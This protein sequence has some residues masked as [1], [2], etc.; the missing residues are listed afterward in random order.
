M[1]KQVKL[2]TPGSEFITIN[3][4]GS[5]SAA[6]G[7]V[8]S[9][10]RVLYVDDGR[11]DS[12]VADGSLSQPFP[13]IMGAVN[14]I[15]S[16]GDNATNAYTVIVNSGVYPESV[17]LENAAL[18]NLSFVANGFVWLTGPSGPSNAVQ[19]T[20]NNNNLIS[21]GFSGFKIGASATT[22]QIKLTCSVNNNMF[23]SVSCEFSTCELGGAVTVSSAGVF[24]L[25]GSQIDATAV[26]LTN[27]GN[28]FSY[29]STAKSAA[30]LAMVTDNGQPIPSG[31]FSGLLF[32]STVVIAA[33]RYRFHCR[34]ELRLTIRPGR[35]LDSRRYFRHGNDWEWRST[36]KFS[37]LH[38]LLTDNGKFG[39]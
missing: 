19:S 17:V 13:T 34:P 3:N 24:G 9:V 26:Q 5:T 11:T 38:C 33:V 28:G 6:S 35:W 25:S 18:V 1:I 32:S 2:N 30:T 15:I 12:F 16:N 31:G 21:L 23:L 7:W 22:G 39:W 20:A 14:Q 8:S 10:T 36:E 37:W 29:G 27:V 4:G